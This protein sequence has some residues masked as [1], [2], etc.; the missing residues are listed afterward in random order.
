MTRTTRR[1]FLAIGAAGGAA[2]ALAACGSDSTSSTPTYDLAPRLTD[3]PLLVPGESRI[4]LS[5][6]AEQTLLSTGPAT[7]KVKVLDGNGTTV[8]EQA[9]DLHATGIPQAYWPLRFTI[10]TPGFYRLSIDGGNPQTGNFGV[11]ETSKVAMP[12]IGSTLPQFDT[13]T[14]DDHRGVEP[15]CSLTPAPCPLHDVTLTQALA[16]GKPLVFMVGTP[17]H[18][19]T[20]AC[21]PALEFLVASHDRVGDQA[22]M[23]HADVFADN[24]ATTYAPIIDALALDYEPVVY[25]ATPGGRVVDRLDGIWDQTEL[26]ERVDALLAH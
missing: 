11:F 17:A 14:V 22:V 1:Q 8:A 25:F 18:C 4:A 12:Y 3:S 10:T 16:S 15:Y 26:D 5:L 2:L 9:A 23:V 21:A 24:A 20:G 6:V 19:Q 13:P 7:L